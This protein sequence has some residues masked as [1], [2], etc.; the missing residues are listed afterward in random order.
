M[1]YDVKKFIVYHFGDIGTGMGAHVFCIQAHRAIVP[2]F[3]FIGA[4]GVGNG[5]FA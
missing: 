5:Y 3:A 4:G 1:S 2:H